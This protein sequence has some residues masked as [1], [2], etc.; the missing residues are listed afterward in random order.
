MQVFDIKIAPGAS[1]LIDQLANYVYFLEGSAGGADTTIVIRPQTGGDAVFLKPGQEYKFDESESDVKWSIANLKGEAE[2]VGKLLFAKGKFGDNRI[3]GSVE[4]ID[5]G[6]NRTSAG[7][8]FMANLY[9]SAVA[10][11]ASKVQ[12]WNPLGSG[13][14]IIIAQ[15]TA[16]IPGGY[17]LVVKLESAPI[18]GPVAA[19]VGSKKAGGPASVALGYYSTADVVPINGGTY[20][21]S[22]GVVCKLTEPI[23]L[24]PGWGMTCGAPV[25]NNAAGAG[26]EFFE[27][28]V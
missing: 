1:R 4:V 24:P 22:S 7:T 11:Q 8:A 14:N 12:L 16:A 21:L 15:L 6:K 5:G 27:E 19:P 23:L 28:F 13:K 20:G 10:G 17:S 2:I 3:S 9:S 18:N 25:L 26:V